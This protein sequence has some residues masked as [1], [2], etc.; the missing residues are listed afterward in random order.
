MGK[1][2]SVTMADIAKRAG[3]C[4]ATVSLA[5]RKHPS[6]PEAT[7]KKIAE[8]AAS[9]GYRPHAALST[10]M[11]RIRSKRSPRMRATIAAVTSWPVYNWLKESRSWRGYFEGAQKRANEQ[12]YQLEEFWLGDKNLTQARVSQI[13]ATRN[14]EGVIVFPCEPGTRM[15]LD[16]KLFACATIGYTLSQPALH[17]TSTAHY[18]AVLTALTELRSR[19]YRRFGLALNRSLNERIERKWLA[20]FMASQF[21]APGTPPNRD[22]IVILDWGEREKFAR[23]YKK[24]RPDVILFDSAVPAREWLGG[25]KARVPEDVALFSLSEHWLNTGCACIDE[26]STEVGAAAVDLVVSQIHRNEKGIPA[27]RQEVFV[28]GSWTEGGTVPPS[29]PPR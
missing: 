10:L 8:T 26:R 3:V 20:A 4:P 17:R 18:E 5:L 13:L 22:S 28:I 16:W 7:R 15:E 2:L 19:G 29:A 9:L 1:I 27:V 11:A 6:I 14:I 24:F 25:L 21:D 12:G 23:W